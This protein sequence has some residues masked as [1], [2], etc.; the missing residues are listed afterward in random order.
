MHHLE[1]SY[2]KY[3]GNIKV[4]WGFFQVPATYTCLSISTSISKLLGYLELFLRSFEI[5]ITR[6]DSICLHKRH[7]LNKL[8][9]C[10]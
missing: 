2:Y 3:H 1:H 5:E 6:F 10:E 9:G 7:R 8:S 4:W